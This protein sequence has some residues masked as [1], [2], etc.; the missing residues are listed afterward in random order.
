MVTV[1]ST[2]PAYSSPMIGNGEITTTIG[3]T[4]YHNGFC[5]PDELVNRT[6]F[7]AGRRLRDA[8]G[9]NIRIPR[10]PPEELIGPTRPLIRFGRLSRTLTVDGVVTADADWVQSVDPDGAVVISTLNH[11]TIREQ[12]RSL[13]CLTANLLV[14]HTR[15]EN[16]GNRSAQ[17][18]FTLDY[19]FGDAEG[20]RSPDT[21]L[22]IRRAPPDDLE[23][24]HVEGTRSLEPDL[25]T[26]PPHVGESLSIQ[27]AVKDQLGEV[28][29]GRYPVGVIRDT[30]YGG[31]FTHEI[32]L[33]PG[34]S[35]DLWFWVAISDRLKYMHFPDFERVTALLAGHER[36]W[37]EFWNT[38][39]VE[40]GDPEMEGLLK[41]C[42]YTMRC[43]ASPWYVPPGYL[44]THWEGRTFHDDFYPFMGLLSGNYRDLAERMPNHRLLTLPHA[45]Q[46]GAGRGAYYAWEFTETGEE[47]APYGHWT[48]EQFRHGQFSEE[49]WRYYL[50]T[51][52]MGALERYYPVMRGCAEWLIHD[53]LVRDEAGRLKTRL[54]TD[55]NETVYPV[56][57]SIFVSCAT[58]RS[59]EN[60][61]RASELMGVDAAQREKWRTLAAELRKT[62]PVGETGQRYR[63][64]DNTDATLGSHHLAMV[65]PFSFDVHGE[66]ACET[67]SRVYDAFQARRAADEDD[68]QVFADNW[69]WELSRMATACFYQ[70]RGDEGYEILRRALD[71]TGPFLAPNEHFRKDG[72]PFLPWFAT[73]AGAFVHAVH[74]MFVRVV[75]ESGPVL[76]HGV[77][78]A[79]HD[80]RFERLLTSGEV[81][82]S[83]EIKDGVLVKLTAESDSA[84]PWHCRIPQRFAETARFAPSVAVSEPDALGLVAVECA[85]GD[86]ETRLV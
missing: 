76:L 46:R 10:V 65:F 22:H 15:L 70:G 28:H 52:D 74:A 2:D 39:R 37:T 1:R 20:V 64:A 41:S 17:L 13:V 29:I 47:S 23:I 82:V 24:G 58:I 84:I 5:P 27:F 77:P 66:R 57:N 40:F 16:Q 86:G 67:L 25:E 73:G 6:I 53:V 43:N 18:T 26:R 7:W 31:R 35:T 72:G 44:S 51:G 85:L 42:L 3:P 36:A 68:D 9:A 14:F 71:V 38:S 56:Y 55:I 81:A 21:W 54:I 45:L 69:I 48:D 79:V 19:E 62:L 63:Y 8:R 32:E 4:G 49:C 80:A 11:G 12:T 61:A 60:A 59:L 83:G 50:Y 34:E 33:E 30:E 78:S 75:D